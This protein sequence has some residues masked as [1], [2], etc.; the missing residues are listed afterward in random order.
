MFRRAGSALIGFPDS[1]NGKWDFEKKELKPGATQRVQT[2]CKAKE[3]RWHYRERGGEIHET[4]LRKVAFFVPNWIGALEGFD[5][6][7]HRRKVEL[8]PLK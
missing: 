1:E 8:P 2:I 6:S 3:G 4:V 7:S 5:R